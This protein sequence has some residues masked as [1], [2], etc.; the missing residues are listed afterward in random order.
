[1]LKLQFHVVAFHV[2]ETPITAVATRIERMIAAFNTQHGCNYKAGTV[3]IYIK[4]QETNPIFY[5]FFFFFF[6][7]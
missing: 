5:E 1:M 6:F 4:K 2:S 7:G 3:I